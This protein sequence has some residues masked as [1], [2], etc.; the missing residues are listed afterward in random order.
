MSLRPKGSSALDP[1]AACAD[2]AEMAKDRYQI[3][4]ASPQGAHALLEAVSA[5]DLQEAELLVGKVVRRRRHELEPDG[6]VSL[7][8]AADEDVGTPS[9]VG[10]HLIPD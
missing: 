10:E 3:W 2:I 9:R 4:Y 8:N 1:I 7:T 6:M 5:A